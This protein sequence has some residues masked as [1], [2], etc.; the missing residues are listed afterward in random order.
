MNV[1]IKAVM[2]TVLYDMFC[3]IKILTCQLKIGVLGCWVNYIQKMYRRH[4]QIVAYES[5]CTSMF[6]KFEDKIC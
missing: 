6:S 1:V 4:V 2:K 5:Y 3:K